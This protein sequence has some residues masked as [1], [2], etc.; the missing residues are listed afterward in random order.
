MAWLADADVVTV[1]ARWGV[2]VE[3]GATTNAGALGQRLFEQTV[4]YAIERTTETDKAFDPP[5][6]PMKEPLSLRGAWAEVTDL[7]AFADYGVTGTTMT[8][9]EDWQIVT[10][11]LPDGTTVVRAVTL[12]FLPGKR[13]RSIQITG[14]R[15]VWLAASIPA[16]V[17]DAAAAM[18]AAQIAAM[19]ESAGSTGDIT[20]VRQGQE[21]V[22]FGRSSNYA[23]WN[24]LTARGK[25]AMEV[26]KAVAE[27]YQI[28]E[29]V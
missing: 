5:E 23:A 10:H 1:L 12:F 9:E 13:R 24:G 26:A 29:V 28:L 2:T 6:Y 27:S 16:E 21:S 4:G 15:G 25:A 11:D 7:K 8:E 18:A 17:K 20:E 14:I 3:S 22:K 19:S